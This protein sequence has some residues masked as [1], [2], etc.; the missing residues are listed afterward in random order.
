MKITEALKKMFR[1]PM[2]ISEIMDAEGVSEAIEKATYGFYDHERVETVAG[3][4]FKTMY[5]VSDKANGYKVIASFAN[6][7]HAVKYAEKT[8]GYNAYIYPY[9]IEI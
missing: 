7:L 9:T 4:T 2:T 8:I 1:K 5:A 3:R 6:E